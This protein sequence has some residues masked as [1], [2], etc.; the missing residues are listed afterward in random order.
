GG[1]DAVT[2]KDDLAAR[3]LEGAGNEIVQRAL[4]GAVGADEAEKLACLHGKAY[5][6]H[7]PQGV[8]GAAEMGDLE[9]AR[10][11][12]RVQRAAMRFK[13]PARP[14]GKYSITTIS[15]AL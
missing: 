10:H 9:Q 15:P 5:V 14:D 4:A 2:G 1:G 8:E 11:G 3:R 7:R 6:A 12:A 13:A